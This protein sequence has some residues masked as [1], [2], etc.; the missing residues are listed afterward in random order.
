M[1]FEDYW[2]IVNRSILQPQ[3]NDQDEQ[4]KFDKAND[5]ALMVIM[6]GVTYDVQPHICDCTKVADAWKK[7]QMVYEAKNKN[8]ILH[9]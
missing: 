5:K 6:L 2:G 7:L 3:I 8:Q 4:V 1:P 9:L